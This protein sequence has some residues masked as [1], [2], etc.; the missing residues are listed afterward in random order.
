MNPGFFCA[1]AGGAVA[2]DLCEA[3]YYCMSGARLPTPEDGG[4]TGDRCPTGHYCPRGSSKPLPC[5]AGHYSNETRNSRLSDCL[6]CPAG[7]TYIGFLFMSLLMG[8][9]TSD[10]CSEMWWITSSRRVPVRLP[11]PFFFIRTPV[12]HQRALFPFSTLSGWFLLSRR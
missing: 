2:S 8:E 7:L 5:P 1:S 6:P 12:C 4:T 10:F 3:G 11:P 9:Q